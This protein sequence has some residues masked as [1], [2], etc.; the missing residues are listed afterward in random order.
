M[1]IAI[2]EAALEDLDRTL[3]TLSSAGHVCFGARCDERFRY[4]LGE[5]A[6][7]LI[8]LDWANPDSGRRETL[9]YLAQYESAIP[10][11]LCVSSCTAHDVMASRM[12]HG[13]S[14][15]IEKPFN[16]IES[17]AALHA[18]IKYCLSP[19]PAV[20]YRLM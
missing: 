2:L 11:L 19:A 16:S 7:D 6:F 14:F 4:L 15:S 18:L 17:R 20:G 12:Q 13:T 8:L 9:R 5:I 3:E 1:K 10:V